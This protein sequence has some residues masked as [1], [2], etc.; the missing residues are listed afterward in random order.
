MRLR[1][2]SFSAAASAPSRRFSALRSRAP[3]QRALVAALA[4]FGVALLLFA[5][6]R[7]ASVRPGRPCEGRCASALLART[8]HQLASL[9]GEPLP[10]RV[11]S[12]RLRA[13]RPF[14]LAVCDD[15]GC[16]VCDFVEQRGWF[17]PVE[18]LAFEHILSSPLCDG[19]R[20][21][22]DVGANV[23]FFTALAA[24]YE[25]APLVALEPNAAPALLA[26]ASLALNGA[27]HRVALLPLAV[28]AVAGAASVDAAEGDPR[29][30][31]AAV[32]ELPRDAAAMQRK[33][34]LTPPPA[35]TAAGRPPAPHSPGPPLAPGAVAMLPLSEL[36]GLNRDLL[37][38]KIDTEGFEAD[39][40]AGCW[41]LW[42]S[43]RVV[44]H[45]LIEVK[46]WNSRPKR[47]ML[48][49][50]MRTGG[51]AAAYTYRELYGGPRLTKLADVVLDGRLQDVTEVIMQA[52]YD[53]TLHFEDY[54]LV[55]QPLPRRMLAPVLAT[56]AAEEEG[57]EE[58]GRGRA[59][60][61]QTMPG[62]RGAAG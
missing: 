49:H 3:R 32:R 59:G 27:S 9:T 57:E 45:L 50:V 40:L 18:S 19:T 21:V 51:F 53:V 47:D 22:V 35:P 37:L 54:W 60:R 8:A 2:T 29:W 20:A 14:D 5:H 56:D 33:R 16:D 41:A 39:V 44:H 23:G 11:R 52:Q 38:L 36:P 46:D 34:G 42:D 13:A 4:A 12:V 28:G 62:R 31:L 15:C 30:G 1:G 25:C 17:A 24:Q 48:R 7:G 61:T 26:A 43:G 58:Q 10:A 6:L 55:R